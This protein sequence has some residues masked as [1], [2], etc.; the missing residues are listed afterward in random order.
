MAHG[1]HSRDREFLVRSCG[2][3]LHGDA[4]LVHEDARDPGR[5]V[6]LP[7]GHVEFGESLT[8]C[9]SREFYEETGL[10]VE[11][12]KL[13]YVHENFYRHRGVRTHEIGFY[14]LLDLASEFPTP[15]SRGYLSS[16]EAH[17]RIRLLPLSALREHNLVPSF[18]QDALPRDVREHFAHPTRHLMAREE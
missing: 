6:A 16:R 1:S 12:E 4:V 2:I 7:G 18:L 8:S 10:N 9:L 15:D 11:P 14:F 17:L 13:V 5:F 3:L